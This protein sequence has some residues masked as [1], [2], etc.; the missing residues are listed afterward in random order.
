[1]DPEQ[2]QALRANLF[3][4]LGEPTG[5]FTLGATACAVR[6]TVPD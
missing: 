3:S 5:G 4:G 6:G 1:L 2:Q